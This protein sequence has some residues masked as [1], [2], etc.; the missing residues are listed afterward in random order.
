MRITDV[1]LEGSEGIVRI[2]ESETRGI[3]LF[4][5]PDGVA[6]VAAGDRRFCEEATVTYDRFRWEFASDTYEHLNGVRGT[7]SDIQPIFEMIGQVAGVGD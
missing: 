2:R 7:N 4:G 5:D 3:V 1:T 6:K